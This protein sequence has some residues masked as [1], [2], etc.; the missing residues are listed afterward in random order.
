M[1]ALLT[2]G[3]LAVAQIDVAG[4]IRA[5]ESRTHGG[6]ASS[7]LSRLSSYTGLRPEQRI[8]IAGRNVSVRGQ[9]NRVQL[10]S[11]RAEEGGFFKSFGTQKVKAGTQ[12]GGK[13]GTQRGT[14]VKKS[15]KAEP[16]EKTDFGTQIFKA[17][18]AA[19]PSEGKVGGGTSKTTLSLVRKE[20][21]GLAALQA[22]GRGRK[23]DPTIVFVAGATGQT[24]SRITKELLQAGFTVRAGVP[25]IV[26]A[27]QLAE[28]ATQ[29]GV[30][31]REEAKRLNVVEFDLRD[32]ESI[33][34][35]IGNSGNVVVTLGA[36]EDGPR[37]KVE[38]K[39]AGRVV[40]AALVARSTNFVL[41]SPSGSAGGGGGGF[42]SGLFNLFG[43]G[44]G[45]VT[46]VDALIEKL[47]ES[48]LKYT[49]LRTG[50]LE[51]SDEVLGNLVLQPEGTIKAPG[52]VGKGQI[53]ELVAGA[54]SNLPV[55][56]DKV[57]DVT[58][59]PAAPALAI[60][61]LLSAVA[62]DGR[63]AS[64][65]AEKARIEAE[66]DAK[67]VAES[68][69]K[70]SAEA[71]ELEAEARKLAQEEAKLAAVMTK[72]QEKA[73]SASNLVLGVASKLS[74]V[75]APKASEPVKS[76]FGIKPKAAETSPQEDDSSSGFGGLFKG[77]LPKPPT[78]PAFSF[79]SFAPAAAPKAAVAAEPAPARA[80][81]RP[82]LK[83][84]KPAVRE[85]PP[86]PPKPTQ[87]P[88][89]RKALGGIV[90][91]E[92]LYADEDAGDF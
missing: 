85:P 76:K 80:S 57:V 48:E 2:Q 9:P 40:E 84:A 8:R 90:K 42:F 23:A 83:Q 11:V 91:Q 81:K 4:R 88:Q 3:G 55:S 52:K 87:K 35:A 68:A 16:K 28:F 30:I 64:V 21:Q 47:V 29:Y 92:T 33:A 14:A 39:D 41:V 60:V 19:V 20:P 34:K 77:G 27:Q 24:G 25:D 86:P 65:A 13:K 43:G 18:Q 63:R 12:K 70:A 1:A 45:G 73:K 26:F 49:V 54:L 5:V 79:G 22:F 32:A 82:T 53:A 51:D 15:G 62:V 78:V 59:D 31:K 75:G 46:S 38:V 7:S 6:G 66:A 56:E 71:A 44:G 36:A 17:F 61:D 58:A 74:Q 72:A 67:V 89:E 50:P 10:Q 37:G 69:R